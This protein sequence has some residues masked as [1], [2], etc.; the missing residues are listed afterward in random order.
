MSGPRFNADQ[1]RFFARI[2]RLQASSIF[3]AMAWHHAVVSIGR[4]Y[5]QGR[6]VRAILNIVIRRIGQKFPEI[7]FFVRIAII[8]DPIASGSKPVEAQHVHHAHSGVTG[9]EQVWPLVHHRADEQAAIGTPFNRQTIFLRNTLGDQIFTGSDEII[10]HILFVLQ[11]TAIM[12][13]LAIFTAAAQIGRGIDAACF[14]P[15][16]FRGAI[17]G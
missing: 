8:V 11:A 17:T 1:V 13:F 6:I 4:G 5:D 9:R 16:H 12:P 3:K 14:N 10:E 15:C 2:Q 7:R